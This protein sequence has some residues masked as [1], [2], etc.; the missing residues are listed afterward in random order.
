MGIGK[1]ER[2][3]EFLEEGGGEFGGRGSDGKGK[4]LF[5]EARLG[6]GNQSSGKEFSDPS[7]GEGGLGFR[8]GGYNKVVVLDGVVYRTHITV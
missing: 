2:S 6:V 1:N 8:F 5:G 4:E 3:N 7:F